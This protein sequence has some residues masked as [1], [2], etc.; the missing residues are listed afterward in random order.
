M[1]FRLDGSIRHLLLDEFQDTSPV[2]WRVIR[3]LAESVTRKTGGSFFCVGDVKQAI[4][5]WRGGMVEILNTLQGSL[6]Q[7]QES[8]AAA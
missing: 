5:G 6:G 1:A 4:Y 2:Q 8:P 7:L 3:P